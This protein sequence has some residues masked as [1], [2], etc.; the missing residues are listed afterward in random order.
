MAAIG[1]ATSVTIKRAPIVAGTA[2]RR[3]TDA[4]GT[5]RFKVGS[6]KSECALIVSEKL[7]D[8]GLDL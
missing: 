4:T 5:D 3:R 1:A 6:S 2:V 8:L 7:F